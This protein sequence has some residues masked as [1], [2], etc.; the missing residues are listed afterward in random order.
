M[1]YLL[2][3]LLSFCFLLSN[4]LDRKDYRIRKDLENFEVLSNQVR[5]E[6]EL[7]NFIES[8]MQ[9]GNVPGLSVAVIK[10]EYIVWN[11][12]LIHISEPTRPY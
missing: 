1:K 8:V 4:D 7:I 5:S 2:L 3:L 6:E 10:D 9:S 12:S 11:L